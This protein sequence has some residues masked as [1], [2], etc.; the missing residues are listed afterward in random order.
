MGILRKRGETIDFTLWQKRG[1]IKVPEQ[2]S[3]GLRGT[4]D[5]FID[6]RGTAE[7]APATETANTGSQFDFLSSLASSS[8]STLT[9]TSSFGQADGAEVNALKIKIEDLEYKIARLMERIAEMEARMK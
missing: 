5:G 8:S 1:L 7:Q 4:I 9:P 6:L 2:K 3:S